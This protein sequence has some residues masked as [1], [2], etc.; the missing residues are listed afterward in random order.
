[1]FKHLPAVML[2]ACLASP[3]STPA[4]A[5]KANQQQLNARMSTPMFV[6]DATAGNRFEIQSG[7]LALSR[8]HA[9][10]VRSFAR[11]LITDHRAAARDMRAA[12]KSGGLKAPP[13]RLDAQHLRMLSEIRNARASAFDRTFIEAQVDAHQKAIALHRNYARN[14]QN[15]QLRQFAQ[16]VLPALREHLDIASRLDRRL[17][18]AAQR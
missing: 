16:N 6:R 8:S 2:I 18:A 7:Q 1:M 11:R 15:A 14:G 17:T 3:L 4:S 13:D 9:Q 12:I 10:G 5:Q